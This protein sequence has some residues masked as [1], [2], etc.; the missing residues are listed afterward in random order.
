MSRHSVVAPILA[1]PL[2]TDTRRLTVGPGTREDH[3]AGQ[4]R[5]LWRTRRVGVPGFRTYFGR[6]RHEFHLD[7][8][9]AVPRLG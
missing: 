5:D 9:R 1:A 8:L 6:S 3:D 4:V 7:A 2:L